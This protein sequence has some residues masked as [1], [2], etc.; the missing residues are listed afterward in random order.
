MCC[1]NLYTCCGSSVPVEE[2]DVVLIGAGSMSIT[3]GLMLAQLNKNNKRY[4]IKCFERLDAVAKESTNGW[5]NAGT[6]H[7]ALCEPNYTPFADSSEQSVNI[8]KA[9]T[10]NENFQLSRQYWAHLV[11]EGLINDPNTFINVT[12]HI[13]FG[14][15][16]QLDWAQKR[17]DALKDHALFEGIEHTTDHKKNEGVVPAYV[18]RATCG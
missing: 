7:A 4:K 8:S 2:V 15:G 17:Y 10:V 5:N 14:V 11:K 18:Q 16:D 12:P 1:G 13:T 3:V 9:V 6:G